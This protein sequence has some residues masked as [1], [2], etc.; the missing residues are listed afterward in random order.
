MENTP[1]IWIQRRSRSIKHQ[2]LSMHLSFFL[3][4]SSFLLKRLRILESWWW[5]GTPLFLFL[6]LFSF[7]HYLLSNLH[8]RTLEVGNYLEL[9]VRK[10]MEYISDYLLGNAKLSNY[11]L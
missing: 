11:V 3:S 2:Y 5:L 10:I 1:T 9:L 4:F 8:G 7:T 6:F